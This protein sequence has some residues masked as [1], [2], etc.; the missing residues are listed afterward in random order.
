MKLYFIMVLQNNNITHFPK[1]DLSVLLFCV[2][3]YYQ[4]PLK[5]LKV[6]KYLVRKIVQKAGAHALH[7]RGLNLIPKTPWYPSITGYGP[8]N[9]TLSSSKSTIKK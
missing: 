8:Q 6:F 9:Q 1:R 4:L 2:G 5:Y 3:R 7:I